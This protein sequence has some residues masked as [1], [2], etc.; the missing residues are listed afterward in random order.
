MARFAAT[1]GP[2]AW[3]VA[4]QRIQQAL[5][6]GCKFGRGWVGEYEPLPTPV[7]MLHRRF[8]KQ[9][10]LVT[11]FQST[12]LGKDDRN[13]K[14]V[15]S[16]TQHPVNER[17]FDGKQPSVRPGSGL[18]PEGKPS[19]FGSAGIRPNASVNHLHQQPNVQTRNQGKPENKGLKQVELNS[20][21]SSDQNNAS[22]V[23]KLTSSTPP[24]VSKPREIVPSSL[25]P[26]REMVPSSV[27]ISP[28]VPFKQ[29]DTNGVVS[30]ELP[31]GKVRNIN[32]N[33]RMTCP[34]SESTS[35]QTG[36]AAPFAA[37]GQEQTLSDPVQLMRMLAEKAQKQQTSSSSNHSPADTPP[38]T[39]SVPSSR[40]EDSGN[41]AA[42]AAR[43]WMSV[44]AA[45]FKQGP[46][47]SSS[48]KNQNSADSLYNPAR[49]FH[50]HMSR[51]RG[52]SEF[53]QHMSQMPFQPEKNNFPFQALG[54]QPIHGHTV[55]VSQFPNRPM[56][57]PQVAASDLSRFQMQPP[58][59]GVRPQNQPRQ[60]QESLPPDL[61]IGFHSPGSPAKQSSGMLVDSQ[62]PDLALQ[63]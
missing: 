4:S 31:N 39:P 14:N 37:H 23:A 9:P 54:P 59:R 6:S 13:R 56:V 49:E 60:K 53:H 2:T 63:L 62:Q 8:Q 35:S 34:S 57:F 44:G 27:N 61:N 15:E 46:D 12:E 58:W 20:L 16:I 22:L 1:L 47:N 42:A 24:A 36:R 52:E 10:S 28:S 18:T 51:I 11:K 21:P 30:G 25:T 43:A 48:P 38:V 45:G 32:I 26:P 40:R 19:L 5:P 7:L 17:M 29:P 41:A 33:R 50:Q 3:R 55:G